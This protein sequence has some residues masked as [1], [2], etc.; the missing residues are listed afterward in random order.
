MSFTARLMQ[1]IAFGLFPSEEYVLLIQFGPSTILPAGAQVTL[2]AFCLVGF[3]LFDLVYLAVVVVYVTQCELVRTVVDARSNDILL[4]RQN[5]IAL[6][7]EE[8][9]QV[10]IC[11]TIM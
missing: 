4:R 3:V 9:I 6:S 1:A 7:L 8:A 11:I 10:S 2:A 5:R